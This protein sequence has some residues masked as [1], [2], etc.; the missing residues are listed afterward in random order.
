[1]EQLSEVDLWYGWEKKKWIESRM[2]WTNY[3]AEPSE[4]SIQTL[5]KILNQGFFRRGFR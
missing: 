1:M 3:R 5:K 2:G 4:K